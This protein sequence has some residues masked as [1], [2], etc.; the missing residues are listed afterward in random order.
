MP[1]EITNILSQESRQ[2]LHKPIGLLL[3]ALPCFH[4]S[5]FGSVPSPFLPLQ[6]FIT[7]FLF[8]L[9]CC[10]HLIPAPSLLLSFFLSFFV[11]WLSSL[12]LLYPCQRSSHYPPPPL[13]M[14]SPPPYP[15]PCFP[16]YILSFP[17]P[18]PWHRGTDLAIQMQIGCGKGAFMDHQMGSEGVAVCLPPQWRRVEGCCE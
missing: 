13:L 17:A 16:S 8:F 5:A 10:F 7:S 3:P 9:L 4:V 14:L 1:D 11:S 2:P 6:T 15:V 18:R 12:Y